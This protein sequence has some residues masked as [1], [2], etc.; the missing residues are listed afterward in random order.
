MVIVSEHS[1]QT[2]TNVFVSKD[3]F[4]LVE[5]AVSSKAYC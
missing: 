1:Q 4:L 3:D 5:C 2:P